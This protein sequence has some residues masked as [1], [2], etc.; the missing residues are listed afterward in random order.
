MRFTIQNVP[1]KSR[2][3]R[4]CRCSRTK[5]TIQNVPIKSLCFLAVSNAKFNL[6]YRMFLLNGSILKIFYS[7]IVIYNTECSY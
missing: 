2:H 5:F 6:Q 3:N 7:I 1:I 4:N